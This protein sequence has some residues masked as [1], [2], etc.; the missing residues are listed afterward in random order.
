MKWACGER[1]VK[2]GWE[3]YPWQLNCKQPLEAVT[4]TTLV[5]QVTCEKQITIQ[6]R[7]WRLNRELS[8]FV[9]LRCSTR[10]HFAKMKSIS[11][12]ESATVRT[13]FSFLTVCVLSCSY[14]KIDILHCHVLLLPQQQLLVDYY[15]YT[16][17]N[18]YYLSVD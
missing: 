9:T 13:T 1:Q 4:K 10:F 16:E 15:C 7:L 18:I 2:I 3:S 14:T 11:G 6:K 17:V 5:S 12:I 8:V